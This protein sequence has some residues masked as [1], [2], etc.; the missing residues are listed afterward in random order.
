VREIGGGARNHTNR[1]SLTASPRN[2]SAGLNGDAPL[3]DDAVLPLNG[4]SATL[5]PPC[6]LPLNVGAAKQDNRNREENREGAWHDGAENNSDAGKTYAFEGQQIRLLPA[7]FKRWQAAYSN[8][9]DLSAALQRIDD[10]YA[11]H[12]PSDGKWFFRVSRWLEK[13]NSKLAEKRLVAE[14]EQHSW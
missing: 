4:H 13:E 7:Q 5:A 8:I 1:Y 2:G 3:N 6:Q 10:Y 11:E 9:P 12:P 14:R